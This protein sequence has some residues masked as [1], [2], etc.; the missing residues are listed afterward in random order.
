MAY[1]SVVETKGIL[2]LVVVSEAD[3]HEPLHAYSC[4]VIIIIAV[5]FKFTQVKCRLVATID[6]YQ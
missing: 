4:G 1:R 6:R 2:T 5:L 3:N